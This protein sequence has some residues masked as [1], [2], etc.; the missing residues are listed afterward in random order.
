MRI[1][2]DASQTGPGKAGCGFYAHGL[3]E[4]LTRRD[5]VNEYICYPT[6]GDH[7]YDPQIQCN[8]W[9]AGRNLKVGPHHSHAEAKKFWGHPGPSF[10]SDLGNPDIVHA[11][12]FFAPTGLVH[13][14][15]VYT[16]YDLA[17]L[18]NWAWTTELN[19][20]ACFDGLFRASL[21][22]DWLVAISQYS[23]E[24]FLHTFAH[25]PPDRISVVYP[26]SRFANMGS[27]KAPT[28]PKL[29]SR[30]FWLCVGTVEP[31]K[32]YKAVL[33]A[34]SNLQARLGWQAYPLVIAGGTGW[35]M[36]I[37]AEIERLKLSRS[38]VLLGYVDD[39]V[40]RWLYRNTTCLVFPSFYEGFGMPVLEAMSCGSPII[41][42]TG[43]AFPEIVGDGELSRFL[44]DPHDSSSIYNAMYAV[45]CMS[46]TEIDQL[47]EAARKRAERFSWTRS[48][49]SVLEVYRQV[50]DTPKLFGQGRTGAATNPPN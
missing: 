2:F 9:T 5:E 35:I 28:Q 16:V 29:E 13:A 22:A 31:R 46:A 23:K 44:V 38:V 20:T 36:D 3:I 6:F 49:C 4:A 11:N 45:S 12:N 7:F 27:E 43:S 26:A 48:A 42:A 17:F 21:Y 40:L 32:N 34:Y 50:M 8:E 15:L 47:G 14:R 30:K 19:R 39:A 24:R 33:S 41:A 10:E 37:K 18:E 1:G 25:Y